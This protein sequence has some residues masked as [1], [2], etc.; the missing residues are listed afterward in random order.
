[1]T[2]AADQTSSI[3]KMIEQLLERGEVALVVTKVS[4]PGA[5]GAK[6]LVREGDVALGSLGDLFVRLAR[7]KSRVTL[8]RFTR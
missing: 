1:M 5:I 7:H 4:G 8:S 3:V 6:L 2:Q